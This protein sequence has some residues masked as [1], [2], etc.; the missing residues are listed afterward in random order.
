M[1]PAQQ[2][3]SMRKMETKKCANPECDTV[4]TGLVKKQYCDRCMRNMKQ[5]RYDAKK[6]GELS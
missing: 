5:R 3:A 4:F 1:N 2:L 6:R